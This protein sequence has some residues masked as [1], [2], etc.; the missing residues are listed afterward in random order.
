MECLPAKINFR[1][2]EIN[3]SQEEMKACLDVMEAYPEMMEANK[4]ELE[5]NQEKREYV[6]A[7]C[8]PTSR[9]DIIHGDCKQVTYMETIEAPENQFW[10]QHLSTG[11]Q[12]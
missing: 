8:L 4:E 3:A 9:A 2:K 6:K 5:A 11:Y 10:D 1:H 7:T 12:N